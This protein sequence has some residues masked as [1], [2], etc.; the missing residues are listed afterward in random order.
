MFKRRNKRTYARVVADGIY[1]KGGWTRALSYLLYRL[2][3]LPDPPHKI[4]R[5]VAVG[6]FA[7]FTPFFGGHIILAMIMAFVLQGNILAAILATFFGNPIT[8]P[9]IALVS[10]ELG[11]WMLGL[12]GDLSLPQVVGSF[13]YATVE[14]WKNVS[15]I[16]TAEVVHWE[17]LGWFFHR[18]FMPYL[19]G[20]IVPG[21]I[22]GTV[23]YSLS[24]RLISV[25]QKSRIKRLKKRYQK[26]RLAEAARADA[27][28][29][30]D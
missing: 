17:R 10:V 24:H 18:I 3:R 1:P 16:F 25:Y 13:S 21:I 22:T 26:R 28:S 29:R 19:V 7:C 8:F 14:V 2:R 20:G 9:I 11:S 6:V 30:I 27:A 15:A 23:A 12:P 5:G 4:A